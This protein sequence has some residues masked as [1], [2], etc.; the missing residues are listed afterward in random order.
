MTSK[1]TTGK[2]PGPTAE[3]LSKFAQDYQA[4]AELVSVD[5]ELESPCYF[6][7]AHAIELAFKAYLSSH[8]CTVPRIHDLASLRKQCENK[9]LP[10]STD[11]TEVVRLLGSEN[12]HHG[13]RYY[14]HVSAAKPELGYL[15]TV[16]HDLV[17][18]VATEVANRPGKRKGQR[19]GQSVV[20]KFT[21]GKAEKKS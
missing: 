21:V 19:K 2:V 14:A 15:R 4:A 1:N 18:A 3:S 6:L 8:N 9:G 10:P 5:K 20:M 17:T 12:Q 11:L 13:F 16:T 7:C